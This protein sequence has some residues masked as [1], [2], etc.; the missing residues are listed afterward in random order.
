MALFDTDTKTMPGKIKIIIPSIIILV[1]ASIFAAYYFGY[2]SGQ[3]AVLLPKE[4]VGIIQTPGKE[5]EEIFSRSG[6]I[7]EIRTNAFVI[8]SNAKT[9]TVD[10]NDKTEF[11]SYHPSAADFGLPASLPELKIGDYIETTAANNIK[12]KTEFTAEMI[13]YT[14]E[15]QGGVFPTKTATS[16]TL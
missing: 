2:K 9:F 8:E 16:T 15:N 10:T 3:Q 1:V 4:K 11:S 14:I 12:N 5:S 7:T 6:K 13:K